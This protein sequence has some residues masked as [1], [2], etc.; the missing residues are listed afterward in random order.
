MDDNDSKLNNQEIRILPA[1]APRD[2]KLGWKVYE[3][4]GAKIYKDI[5]SKAPLLKYDDIQKGDEIYAYGVKAIVK[6]GYATSGH[7]VFT[8]EYDKDDR[9]CWVCIGIGNM[10]GLE[11]LQL[12]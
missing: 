7:Y 8:L 1:D 11:K 10:R 5:A 9:H 2:I 3:Y 12:K 4:M 6:E